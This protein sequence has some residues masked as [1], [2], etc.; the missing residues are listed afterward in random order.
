MK[1]YQKYVVS[2]VAALSLFA[3]TA[4]MAQCYGGHCGGYGGCPTCRTC[5]HT[6]ST[7]GPT[8][9]YHTCDTCGYRGGFFGLFDW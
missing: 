6:C 7:C 8:Y 4:V 5:F 1:T 9:Y 3:S 2:A